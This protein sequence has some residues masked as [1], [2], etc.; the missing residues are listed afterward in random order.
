MGRFLSKRE[1]III[2]ICI[3]IGLLTYMLIHSQKKEQHAVA[4]VSCDGKII[5]VINLDEDNIYHIDAEYPATLV[6]KDGAIC[7]ID[8][9]CPNHDC[10]RFGYIHI[11]NESAICL[12]AKLSVQIIYS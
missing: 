7:F 8:S 11:P 6:V 5:M 4:Q 10:E 3:A 1:L 9:V 12:P 2:I